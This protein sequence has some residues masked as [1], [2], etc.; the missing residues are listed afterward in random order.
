VIVRKHTFLNEEAWKT[1]P[2]SAGTSTKDILHHLL[3]LTVEIPAL[4]EEADNLGVS[5]LMSP[6]DE[7]DL[8]ARRLQLWERIADLTQRMQQ[9]KKDWVDCYPAGLPREVDSQTNDDNDPFPI[10]H[11]HN[12]WTMQTVRP[13]TIVYPDLRLAQSMCIYFTYR[14]I[15]STIDTRPEGS[16]SL[17]EKY[18]LGCDIARS[19]ECYI[20]MSP[21]NMVSRLALVVRVAWEVFPECGIEREFITEV[22]ILVRRRHSLHLCGGSMPVLSTRLIKFATMRGGT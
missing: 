13:P 2:W 1:I 7:V 5:G 12:L 11:C 3:D 20:R 21:S 6:P 15:L 10:F 8:Q 16:V 17:V 9:W 4:L 19:L 14:V 22:V 18:Q